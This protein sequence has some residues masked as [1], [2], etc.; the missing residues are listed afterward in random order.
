MVMHTTTLEKHFQFLKNIW[1]RIHNI[2]TKIID[3][4]GVVALVVIGFL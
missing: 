2:S 1:K 3:N 4:F